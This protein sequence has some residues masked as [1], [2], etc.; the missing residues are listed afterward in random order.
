M[1]NAE[2]AALLC[3][4]VFVLA[5]GVYFFFKSNN[6]GGDE[7]SYFLGGRSMNGWVSAL[8]AG[9]SDMSAWVLMGLPGSIYLYGVGQIWIAI[10]LMLG[11]FTA[12]LSV[13]PRLRRYSIVAGDAITVP[14]F[15]TRRFRTDQIG[16]AHV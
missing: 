3:Y 8:S 6:K 1:K 9:A 13:A 2:L 16:R 12:W 14:Q 7:K 4:F 15:L 10:G 5:I 11:T